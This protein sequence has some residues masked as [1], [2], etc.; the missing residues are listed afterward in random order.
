MDWCRT[1]LVLGIAAA[2]MSSSPWAHADSGSCPSPAASYAGGAGTVGAPYQVAT[3]EQL[4]R[5]RDDSPSWGA[6]FVVTAIIDMTASGATCTW[7]SSIGTAATPFTGTFDGAGREIVD[8]NIAPPVGTA[9]YA[10]LFG[11]IS[12]ASII[13]V[14]FAGDVTA[15]AEAAHGPIARAGGLVGW[16]DGASTITGGSSAG[17]IS[18]I[19]DDTV[20]PGDANSS[21]G[22]LV[23]LLDGTSTV[24]MSASSG[25]ATAVMWADD[26]GSTLSSGAAD[27][28]GLVGTAA[29]GTTISNSSATGLVTAISNQHAYSSGPVTPRAGGLV[30]ASVGSTQR[31][32]ASGAA[33]ANGSTTGMANGMA[34]GLAGYVGPPGSV[35]DSY[36]TGSANASG[37]FDGDSFAGG[38]IGALGSSATITSTYALGSVTAAQSGVGS[39]YRGALIGQNL[40]TVQSSFASNASTPPTGNAANTGITWTMLA[41]MQDIAS[42]QSSGWSISDTWSVGGTWALCT[43]V[44]N[45][46][47]F[48][49]SQ[50]TSNPGCSAGPAPSPEVPTPIPPTSPLAVT[51]I[52]GDRTAEVS[53]GEPASSGSYPV[54]HYMA[55]SSLG[56][57][58]CLVA[59][60]ALSCEVGGL[61]NG[62]AYT[63][64]VKALTGA[65]W[66]P[67]SQ[68]SNVV[69][70]RAD[71]GPLVVITGARDGRSITVSGTSTG[72]GMGA[73]LN[74]WVRLAG[75]SSFTEGS[76]SILVSMDGTFE[77]SRR[78]GKRVS[79]YVEMRDSSVRSNTVTIR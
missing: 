13:D 35:I 18:A 70:P 30:G 8:L 45:N 53:W 16:A 47:P 50:F 73:I 48:L 19:A 5:L 61:T 7:E 15:A 2:T 11:R 20:A 79:V 56:G 32:T 23:G 72:L 28:G 57:R 31:S 3:P 33:T 66:S 36:A 12:G 52:G 76:A 67:A 51:A 55:T 6:S 9:V 71:A 37:G 25:V 4:Q 40:G 43:G 75:Q 41:N 39:A 65:G 42:Y 34:G 74:P 69:V 46:Y 1:F 10:G 49:V 38:L 58:T 77:W 24:S 63:F 27:A 22:G 17:A 68:A 29:S 44:N 26:S 62:T 78:S 21:A 54:S 60:P 59:A 64:T 14:D